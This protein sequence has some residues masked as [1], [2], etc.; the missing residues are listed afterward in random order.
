M[1][2]EDEEEEG[3]GN[4]DAVFMVNEYKMSCFT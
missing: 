3:G 2:G 4:D 1:A